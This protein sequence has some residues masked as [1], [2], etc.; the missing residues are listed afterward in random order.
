MK[1]S[2]YLLSNDV[3][4]LFE[5]VRANGQVVAHWPCNDHD[6]HDTVE[7]VSFNNGYRRSV[8]APCKESAIKRT[9]NEW[10]CEREGYVYTKGSRFDFVRSNKG[11]DFDEN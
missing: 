10:A 2:K 6:D 7:R 1:R 5:N 9:V 8:T 4:A 3:N 11:K